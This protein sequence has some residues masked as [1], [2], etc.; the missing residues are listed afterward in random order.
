MVCRQVCCQCSR[1][2][3]LGMPDLENN[4]FTERLA[5]LGQSLLRDM[6]WGQKV[7]CLSSS[8]SDPKAEG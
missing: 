2:G 8:Q 5:C 4:W 3:G 6:V 7:R 1:N